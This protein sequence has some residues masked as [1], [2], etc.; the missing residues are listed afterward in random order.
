M[1]NILLPHHRLGD[2]KLL[3]V[4]WFYNCFIPA[5]CSHQWL[6][7]A[8]GVTPDSYSAPAPEIFRNV[9]VHYCLLLTRWEWS[10]FLT[11]RHND[12]TGTD[13]ID[14]NN[15]ISKMMIQMTMMM[16]GT[17]QWGG[18]GRLVNTIV[19]C[20]LSPVRCHVSCHKWCY[21]SWWH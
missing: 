9:Q 19:T 21:L 3:G 15:D 14:D 17:G 13:D 2:G 1:P 4:I 20:V 11:V 16:T 7:W 5:Q 18:R 6:Q 8:S 10:Q 12:I